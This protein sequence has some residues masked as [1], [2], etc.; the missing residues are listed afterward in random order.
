[1]LNLSKPKLIFCSEET[2]DK[3]LKFRATESSIEQLVL[4]GGT[5]PPN[6]DVMMFEDILQGN[7]P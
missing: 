5:K 3:M 2:I 4:Y 6:A 1:M 7:R